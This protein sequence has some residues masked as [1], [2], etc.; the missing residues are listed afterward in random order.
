[1][2]SQIPEML[3]CPEAEGAADMLLGHWDDRKKKKYFL[4][5]I[6]TDFA[7]PKA[8]L[9]WYDIVHFVDTLIHFGSVQ[10]T[11]RLGH[12]IIIEKF[13]DFFEIDPERA[14]ENHSQ[15][16]KRGPEVLRVRNRWSHYR[17][18]QELP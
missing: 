15:L 3:T 17:L 1:M 7:K 16:P 2:L 6:G 14:R 9:I 4:F 13:L 10:A 5:G 18:L 12:R 8:P 11:D